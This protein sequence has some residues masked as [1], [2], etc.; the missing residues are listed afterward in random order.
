MSLAGIYAERNRKKR[1]T[2]LEFHKIKTEYVTIQSPVSVTKVTTVPY[3]LTEF[4]SAVDKNITPH[5]VSNRCASRDVSIWKARDFLIDKQ[6]SIH[7]HTTVSNPP[8]TSLRANQFENDRMVT[9]KISN[10]KFVASAAEP[11]I[12]KQKIPGYSEALATTHMRWLGFADA[13]PTE[14]FLRGEMPDSW[15]KLL[16]LADAW[17]NNGDDG[18]DIV[19]TNAVAQVKAN[20]HSENGIKR[21][22]VSQ[23]FGDA[24]YKYG[25]NHQK[26]LLFYAAHYGGN[27][28]DVANK[29]RVA[30]FKINLSG[31]VTPVNEVAQELERSVTRG[32][33]ARKRSRDDAWGR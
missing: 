16:D 2:S 26:K 4:F 5:V 8:S 3:N 11:D 20:F 9:Y 30:L 24:T 10:E 21:A 14:C 6:V 12:R 33:D 7:T 17:V 23:L 32:D 22:L 13:V 19:A 25:F 27:A 31:K 28:R 29:L 18:I 15:D 1:T